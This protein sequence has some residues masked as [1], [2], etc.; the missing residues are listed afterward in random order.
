MALR[1]F[2][3][4]AAVDIISKEKERGPCCLAQSIIYHNAPTMQNKV[5]C[6]QHGS[7]VNHWARP[8]DMFHGNQGHTLF[9]HINKNIEQKDT[10]VSKT[11]SAGLCAGPASKV[12][13]LFT[14]S[15]PVFSRGLKLEYSMRNGWAEGRREE[16]GGSAIS[17]PAR[18]ALGH[19]RNT[20]FFKNGRVR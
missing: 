12:P 19:R 6:R 16:R 1:E 17:E 14:C 10:A 4:W 20:K 18:F 15:L 8:R 3:A 11:T 2:H 5:S 7:V 13:L 9:K